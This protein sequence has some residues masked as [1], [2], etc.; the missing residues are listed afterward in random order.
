[1]QCHAKELTDGEDQ[2]KSSKVLD[3]VV[4]TVPGGPPAR[5]VLH[6]VSEARRSLNTSP[7]ST[8]HCISAGLTWKLG[9]GQLLNAHLIHKSGMS[10]RPQLGQDV[11][12]I[13]PLGQVSVPAQLWQLGYMAVPG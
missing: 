1:M 11:P 3:G 13:I 10:D 7:S 6:Q 12:E 4:D 5:G 9:R 2:Q 8:L